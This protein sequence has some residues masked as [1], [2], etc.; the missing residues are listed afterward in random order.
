MKFMKEKELV[1]K[2]EGASAIYALQRI[3]KLSKKREGI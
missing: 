1:A 3:K 2:Y